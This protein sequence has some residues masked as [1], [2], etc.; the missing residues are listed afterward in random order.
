MDDILLQGRFGNLLFELAHGLSMS[1]VKFKCIDIQCLNN[2]L[3]IVQILNLKHVK[4]MLADDKFID[5][6]INEYFQSEKYFDKDKIKQ[7][8][9][10]EKQYPQYNDF[11]GMSIRLGDY[12]TLNGIWYSSSTEYFEKAYHRY[13]EGKMCLISSD[14][15]EYCKKNLKIPADK[16][17]WADDLANDPLTIMNMLSNCKNF[18]GSSSTFSWWCAW[19]NEENKEK[20]IFPHTWFKENLTL[21][22]HEVEIQNEIVPDRWIKFDYRST[23]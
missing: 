12:I 9:N 14:D 15:V 10:F 23:T 18:I 5:N 8:F 13:F 4:I 11:V 1:N 22:P 6:H 7:L 19:I 20:I 16:I 17:V 2:I 21:K 3:K